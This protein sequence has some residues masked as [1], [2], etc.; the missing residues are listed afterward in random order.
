MAAGRFGQPKQCAQW[1]LDAPALEIL[2]D[3]FDHLG[4]AA[5]GI[6]ALCIGTQAE[7]LCLQAR[8]QMGRV[9]AVGQMS[10]RLRIGKSVRKIRIR[11]THHIFGRDAQG[12]VGFRG[13]HKGFHQHSGPRWRRFGHLL[14]QTPHM[15]RKPRQRPVSIGQA[16]RRRLP[17]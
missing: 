2:S 16:L 10:T 14:P 9:C 7:N 5:L 3:V 8:G 11:L 4:D 1:A 13:F 15:R 12:R 6:A 17:K